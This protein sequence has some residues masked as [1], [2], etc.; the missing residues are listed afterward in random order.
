MNIFFLSR[1]AIKLLVSM[2]AF[3][4]APS[5]EESKE[6]PTKP[7]TL[8]DLFVSPVIVPKGSAFG[9]T[10]GAMNLVRVNGQNTGVTAYYGAGA[11]RYATANSIV[12]DMVNMAKGTAIGPAFPRPKPA[13]TGTTVRMDNGF[14]QDWYLRGPAQAVE[15]VALSLWRQGHAISP[16]GPTT[17]DNR[18]VTA[19]GVSHSALQGLLKR[20]A[21][22]A[23]APGAPTAANAGVVCFPLIKELW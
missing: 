11:G 9:L 10:S 17:G 12:S 1:S 14:Q 15:T 6:G 16:V 2:T 18:A 7:V 20:V 22:K 13:K 5:S 4:P 3:S 21:A 8:L 19:A 23:E